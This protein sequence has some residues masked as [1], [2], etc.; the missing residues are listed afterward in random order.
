M[1]EH[2]P[3]KAATTAAICQPSINA[4]TLHASAAKQLAP[5][6]KRTDYEK[7]RLS[8][9]ILALIERGL[10][11]AVAVGKRQVDAGNVWQGQRSE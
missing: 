4:V 9:V 11:R 8:S 1:V 3:T 7:M 6:I 5:S 10:V 2:K